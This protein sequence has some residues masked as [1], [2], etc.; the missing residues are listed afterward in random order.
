MIATDFR[1]LIVFVVT[2]A[3]WV[4]IEVDLGRRTRRA[5]LTMTNHWS[6]LAINTATLVAVTAAVLLS[7]SV[8]NGR[9]HPAGLAFVIGIA[10]MVGGIAIRTA[11]ARSLGAY[12]TL[13]IGIQSGQAIYC[14]GLY[15]WVRH[16]GY[17]GTLMALLGLSLALGNWYSVA[18][19]AV[20]V[21]ALVARIALEERMLSRALGGEYQTYCGRTRWRLLPGVV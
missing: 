20:I 17:A 14:Q 13:S 6:E 2:V 1:A 11:A 8:P 21:P 4:A 18:A 3:I 9:I 7:T 16:P 19:I 12:Y 10:L 15:R 5:T